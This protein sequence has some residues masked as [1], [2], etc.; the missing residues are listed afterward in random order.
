MSKIGPF[1][2]SEILTQSDPVFEN[3]NI[4]FNANVFVKEY[5]LYRE[6]NV[7][8]EFNAPTISHTRGASIEFKIN[9]GFLEIIDRVAK[10]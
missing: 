10:K 7:C 2:H 6:K 3:F 1:L 9:V 8:I 4:E 5:P